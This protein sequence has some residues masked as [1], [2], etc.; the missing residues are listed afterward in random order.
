MQCKVVHHFWLKSS[1][2]PETKLV[3]MPTLLCQLVLMPTLP[4]PHR[5]NYLTVTLN[6]ILQRCKSITHGLDPRGIRDNPVWVAKKKVEGYHRLYQW[7]GVWGSW[8]K[9]YSL[10]GWLR[11]S[12]LLEM[13]RGL[14]SRRTLMITQP[15]WSLKQRRMPCFQTIPHC[16]PM[17][18]SHSYGLYIKIH[19]NSTKTW[20]YRIE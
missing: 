10:F 17:Y 12:N 6:V 8:L 15:E 14:S 4:N 20:I 2:C 1:S 18:L 5:L 11:E 3:L 19:E 13:M 16:S 7:V 9:L